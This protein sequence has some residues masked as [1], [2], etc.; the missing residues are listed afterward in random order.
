M[1]D[2][3]F[4]EQFGIVI[5]ALA[6][7]ITAIGGVAVVRGRKETKA[8]EGPSQGAVLK[9][10]VETLTAQ[11]EKDAATSASASAAAERQRAEMLG[12][13]RDIHMWMIE[14]AARR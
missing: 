8:V 6:T 14:H 11:M 10:A 3:T 7:L 12:V 1:P 13:L 4:F 2:P 5:G 9:G